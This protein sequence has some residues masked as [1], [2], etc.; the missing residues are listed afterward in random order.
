[1][2]NLNVTVDSRYQEATLSIHFHQLHLELFHFILFHLML[3]LG[4]IL[5]LT[6]LHLTF[7]HLHFIQGA[8]RAIENNY[9]S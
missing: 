2:T 7:L 3:L 9:L 4:M 5:H 6:L 8:L 1:M